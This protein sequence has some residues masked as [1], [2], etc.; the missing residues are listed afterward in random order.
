MAIVKV[1]VNGMMEIGLRIPTRGK[2]IFINNPRNITKAMLSPTEYKKASI[3]LKLSILR[4][5]KIRIPGT[6]LRKKKPT[7]CLIMGI[8]YPIN[9][10]AISPALAAVIASNIRR[11]FLISQLLNAINFNILHYRNFSYS[12]K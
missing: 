6:K 8:S 12:F 3:L 5:L 1:T 4:I 10:S 9:D 7:I 11:H 2:I